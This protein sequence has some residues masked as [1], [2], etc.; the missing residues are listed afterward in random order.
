MADTYGQPGQWSRTSPARN[1]VVTLSGL[2]RDLAVLARVVLQTRGL[3][4][5]I[6]H[7]RDIRHI[8]APTRS[9]R[10]LPHELP[11]A[12]L[13]TGTHNSASLLAVSAQPPSSC[14]GTRCC[15]GTGA[16]DGC[17]TSG[18]GMPGNLTGCGGTAASF[19]QPRE[20]GQSRNRLAGRVADVA[21]A[22]YAPQRW[23]VRCVEVEVTA[24]IHPAG[25]PAGSWRAVPRT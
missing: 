8:H 6:R 4:C 10:R 15:G 13:A 11:C 25:S 22:G 12:F 18:S 9:V 14:S 7:T 16:V 23:G 5:F 1:G 19:F 2:R 21:P 3:G 20:H 24:C 17:P